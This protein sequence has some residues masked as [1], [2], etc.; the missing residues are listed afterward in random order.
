MI[1]FLKEEITHFLLLSWLR[2]K[3]HSIP[4]CVQSQF[5]SIRHN[6]IWIL[7]KPAGKW[8][9]MWFLLLLIL[10]LGLQLWSSSVLRVCSDCSRFDSVHVSSSPSPTFLLSFF[11][12]SFRP[13]LVWVVYK[14]TI[15]KDGL[16][17]NQVS[18][19]SL[20]TRLLAK[21]DASSAS[22]RY[23]SSPDLKKSWN[24]EANKEKLSRLDSAQS[25]EKKRRVEYQSIYEPSRGVPC[26]AVLDQ[27]GLWQYWW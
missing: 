1:W 4:L 27:A 15:T 7:N 5:W 18:I 25:G 19:D 13:S 8:S 26:R 22:R 16:K 10:S 6:S 24:Y 11:L 12:S 14:R 3:S 20:T 21:S 17:W 23:L 2:S 9:K